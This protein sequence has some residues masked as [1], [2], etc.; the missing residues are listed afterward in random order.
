MDG[1]LYIGSWQN[2]SFSSVSIPSLFARGFE[3]S[4]DGSQLVMEFGT[5]DV[6]RATFT[7]FPDQRER[8]IRE[9]LSETLR[10]SYTRYPTSYSAQQSFSPDLK[11]SIVFGFN[12]YP[13]HTVL[14]NGDQT[15]VLPDRSASRTWSADGELFIARNEDGGIRIFNTTDGSK[16]ELAV[17]NFNK[18]PGQGIG[19]FRFSPDKRWV[20][21]TRTTGEDILKAMIGRYAF[22]YMIRTDGS[23]LDSLARG[24]VLSWVSAPN[25][26]ACTPRRSSN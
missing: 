14:F 25:N 8:I 23:H 20:A 6:E 26:N 13:E 3:W 17:S 21:F 18:K 4:T 19:G 7:R 9:A 2:P 10:E 12:G 11:K 15:Q 5:F 22:S 16:R 24:T 1:G